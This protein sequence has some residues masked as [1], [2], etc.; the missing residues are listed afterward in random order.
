MTGGASAIVRDSTLD[1]LFG[2]V[3][4]HTVSAGSIKSLALAG[5]AGV[6]LGGTG[7]SGVLGGAGAGARN[8]VNKTRSADLLSSTVDVGTDSLSVIATDQTE[9]R[10]DAGG[11]GISVGT[12]TGG[13]VDGAIGIA[14]AFNN[15]TQ[16]LTAK[17]DDSTV[18]ADEDI[19]VQAGYEGDPND[20]SLSPAIHAWALAADL[21]GGV[22]SGFNATLAGSGSGAHNKVNST[23]EALVTNDSSLT[24]QDGDIQVLAFDFT[25]IHAWTVGAS[26]GAGGSSGASLQGAVGVSLAKNDVTRTIRAAVTDSVLVASGTGEITVQSTDDATIHAVA[27]AANASISGAKGLAAALTGGGADA[28]NLVITNQ[29]AEVSNSSLTQASKITVK[30]NSTPKIDASV[31]GFFVGLVGAV[32]PA[33]AAAIGASVAN[34][35]IGVNA[36]EMPVPSG[37]LATVA[38]LVDDGERK[39]PCRSHLRCRRR[40][41]RVGRRRGCRR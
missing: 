29:R 21:G 12:G 30:A 22:S 1:V 33:G 38:E 17:V 35:L 25:T 16:S 7:V 34:N 10:A 40:F 41:D 28:T 4:I 24:S 31:Y 5:G 2:D 13:K 26:L 19:V 27:V 8:D 20:P 14:L 15:V 39:R 23:I 6:S 9:V 11:F 37:V 32:G 36:S 18:T 3:A